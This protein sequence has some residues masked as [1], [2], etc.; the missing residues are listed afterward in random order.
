[1]SP[2]FI[3]RP[4][5]PGLPE[6]PDNNL[7]ENFYPLGRS[8]DET[9]RLQQQSRFYDPFTLRLFEDAGISAGMK[10]LDA[11][12]GAGDVSLLAANLVGSSGAVVGVDQDPNVIETA[13]KRSRDAGLENVTF[14]EGNIC[15]VTLETD[16]DA[17]VGRLILMYLPQPV[18]AIRKLLGHL[19]PGGV[20]VFQ[21]TDWTYRPA[22][23]PPSRSAEQVFDWMLQCFQVAGVE[24]QMGLKLY[25]TFLEAG[26]SEP[27]MRLEAP[28][29]GG[30]NWD[31]YDYLANS[32]R[33]MLPA[34]L[35]FNIASAADVEIESLAKR[36]R[37]EI[38]GQNGV[39]MLSPLVGIWAIK[40]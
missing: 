11:G 18:Q 19:R 5:L 39:V 4:G 6:S 2:I 16:F 1:M 12:C 34:L 25:A 7:P 23:H 3:G 13:R 26:I 32:V 22:V 35:K 17:V 24:T 30:P 29:G 14:V 10:V 31:G 8:C 27:H 33:S 28:L 38:A 15:S 40:H 21:E 37:E 9:R 20:V 36:L